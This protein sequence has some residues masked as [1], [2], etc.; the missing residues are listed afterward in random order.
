MIQVTCSSHIDRSHVVALVTP[1]VRITLLVTSVCLVG[2]FELGDS[3]A[4]ENSRD[5]ESE[6]SKASVVPEV[7][8]R[9]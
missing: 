2:L 3:D 4:V 1:S 6:D 5:K 7:Q 9:M 8:E